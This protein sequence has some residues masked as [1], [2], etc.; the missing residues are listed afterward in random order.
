[1]T[2]LG[3]Y[4]GRFMGKPVRVGKYRVHHPPVSVEYMAN[5]SSFNRPDPITTECDIRLPDGEISHEFRKS[6]G[7]LLPDSMHID[8]LKEELREKYPNAV[9]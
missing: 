8:R 5:P 9:L 6:T 4:V 7:I 3:R 2:V 1:M